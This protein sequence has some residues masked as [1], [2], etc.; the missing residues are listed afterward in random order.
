MLVAYLQRLQ[1]II[2]ILTLSHEIT[3]LLTPTEITSFQLQKTLF[4]C[5]QTISNPL[6]YNPYTENI[7]QSSKKKFWKMP[8]RKMIMIMMKML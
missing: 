8:Q 3:Q 2:S 5:F 4:T 6:A 7:W 1:E